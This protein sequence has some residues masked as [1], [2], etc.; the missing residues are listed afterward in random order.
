MPSGYRTRG[1]N[2]TIPLEDSQTKWLSDGPEREKS[3]TS[4]QCTEP[5]ESVTRTVSLSRRGSTGW[6]VTWNSW[7]GLPSERP[8][9]SDG[10]AI[11]CSAVDGRAE[12]R[13]LERTSCGDAW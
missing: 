2:R 10:A 9:I 7:A 11:E 3:A 4:V 12:R 13:R 5:L 1:P 6:N 8:R